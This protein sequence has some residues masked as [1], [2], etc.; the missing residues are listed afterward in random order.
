MTDTR[1][2]NSKIEILLSDARGIYIPQNFAEDMGE[3][4]HLSADD[5]AHLSDPEN[6][7]Y[8]EAWYSVLDNAYFIDGNGRK[9]TLHHDGDLFAIREDFDLENWE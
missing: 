5:I 7:W 9:W 6:E 4:W 3:A 1:L 2:E 8:W